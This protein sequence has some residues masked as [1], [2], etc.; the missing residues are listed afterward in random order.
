MIKKK[1]IEKHARMNIF[2]PEKS[3]YEIPK[4]KTNIF[5]VSQNSKLKPLFSVLY[6][7]QK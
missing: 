3:N 1:S 7:N 2:Q 6:I 5:P 4:M